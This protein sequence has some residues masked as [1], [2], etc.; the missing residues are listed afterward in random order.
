[1]PEQFI[2]Y[3]AP[4]LG[5]EIYHDYTEHTLYHKRA[6]IG[7]LTYA[8][9]N[10]V[11]R[12]DRHNTSNLLAADFPH[13]QKNFQSSDLFRFFK[14]YLSKND[15]KNKVYYEVFAKLAALTLPWQDNIYFA[16]I[17]NP[18]AIGRKIKQQ[19]KKEGLSIYD[20]AAT[21]HLTVSEIVCIE[22][23][24]ELSRVTPLMIYLD[25]IAHIPAARA[26]AIQKYG[27]AIPERAKHRLA[28]NDC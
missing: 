17:Y 12:Y 10:Y 16:P 3:E 20:C 14:Q 13:P 1:M 19:R 5:I 27:N 18:L 28:T 15:H 26:F 24:F 22:N 7:T 6:L 23:A 2:E 4:I 25:I 21:T 11:F 8:K 9:G